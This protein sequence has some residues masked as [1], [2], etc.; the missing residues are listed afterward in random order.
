VDRLDGVP[1]PVSRRTALGGLAVLG[2]AA[3][4]ACT[5]GR[6]TRPAVTV[7]APSRGRSPSGVPADPDVRLAATALHEE[8]AMLDRV[9]ATG[10]VHP[11]LAGPLAGARATHRAHV[12][13]LARA[14]PTGAAARRPARRRQ[15]VP[16]S[17]AA[18]LA[19]LAG[20]EDRLASA[21]GGHALVARSGPFARVLASM[22]ASAA[23]QGA[24]LAAAGEDLR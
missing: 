6:A 16:R 9:L 18:A 13:L 21:G 23:Q 7:P 24:R 17:Q 2:V 1:S 10:R 4:A 15:P 20:A 5:S 14:V 12:D 11:H 3:V 8:Q 19:A 22:A